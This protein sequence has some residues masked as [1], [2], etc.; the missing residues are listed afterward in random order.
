MSDRNRASFGPA[1][2]GI[3]FGPDR[4][5]AWF[6]PDRHSVRFAGVGALVESSDQLTINAGG[7]L[8]LINGSD[9]L[10]IT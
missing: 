5:S 8:L 4:H 6:G 9:V 7:D 1:R 3:R 2:H 10:E